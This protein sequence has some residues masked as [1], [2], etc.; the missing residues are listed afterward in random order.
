MGSLTWFSLAFLVSG[1]AVTVPNTRFCAV[2]GIMEG[3]MD[4]FH[5]LSD[6]EDHIEPTEI[7]NFL[8]A[9][10]DLKDSKGVVLQAGHGAA[11]CQ[12]MEDWG[13]EHEALEA[14]CQKL[15]AACSYDIQKMVNSVTAKV[16]R[17]G[18]AQ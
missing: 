15:G 8:E 5:T 7:K 4:C 17:L 2:A 11:I 9:A 6:D 14:A 1:C 12:P 16:N 10:P 18:V 3:G 13:K